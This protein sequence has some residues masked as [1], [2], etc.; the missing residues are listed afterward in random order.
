LAIGGKRRQAMPNACRRHVVYGFCVIRIDEGR[1][2][3]WVSVAGAT[4]G[5]KALLG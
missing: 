3:A 2:P 1:R 5:T 4:T